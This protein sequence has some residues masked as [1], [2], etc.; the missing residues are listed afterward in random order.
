MSGKTLDRKKAKLSTFYLMKSCKETF[1]Y[2]NPCGYFGM[3]SLW[4]IPTSATAAATAMP[5]KT[6]TRKDDSKRKKRTKMRT[7]ERVYALASEKLC[8]SYVIVPHF[9]EWIWKFCF[10]WFFFG[11][12][13]K[14]FSKKFQKFSSPSNKEW[15]KIPTKKKRPRSLRLSLLFFYFILKTN[16]TFR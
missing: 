15:N 3:G 16:T 4:S 6:T 14:L 11:T 1:I 8:Y 10:Y 7:N 2:Y 5:R 12:V 9:C 13:L